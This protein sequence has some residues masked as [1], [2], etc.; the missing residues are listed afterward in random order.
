MSSK[1]VTAR[2]IDKILTQ[3]QY[4]SDRLKQ[5]GLNTT[6][7]AAFWEATQGCEGEQFFDSFF[8]YASPMLQQ[9]LTME[10]PQKEMIPEQRRFIG[11]YLHD[12]PELLEAVRAY[13]DDEHVDLSEDHARALAEELTDLKKKDGTGS[14]VIVSAFKSAT[15]QKMMPFFPKEM[16]A[17]IGSDLERLKKTDA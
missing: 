17:E 9:R 3:M 7:K 14:Y 1:K 13:E 8:K 4:A 10:M 15:I 2:R 11:Y 6:L 5:G 16:Q 12:K